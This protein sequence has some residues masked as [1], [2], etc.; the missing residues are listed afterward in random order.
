[1]VFCVHYYELECDSVA[2]IKIRSFQLIQDAHDRFS[3]CH[4]YAQ[5]L[6]PLFDLFLLHC[7]HLLSP[8]IPHLKALSFLYG[9][10]YPSVIACPSFNFFRWQ[11]CSW[12]RFLQGGKSELLDFSSTEVP[13]SPLSP[14]CNDRNPLIWIL[15][16]VR[17]LLFFP[18]TLRIFQ[19]SNTELLPTI[20]R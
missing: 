11:Q 5:C 13:R 4:F 6:C 15:F 8:S 1:M 18:W 7:K 3:K 16:A 12:L 19:S 2:S 9:M 17:R 20:I 14:P 10:M